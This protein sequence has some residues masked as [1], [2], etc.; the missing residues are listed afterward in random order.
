MVALVVPANQQPNEEI[1]SK[2]LEIL[3]AAK[4]KLRFDGSLT[5][6]WVDVTGSPWDRNRDG[7]LEIQTAW[8]R[9]HKMHHEARIRKSITIQSLI[10]FPE[11][12]M[13]TTL[14]LSRERANQFIAQL[15]YFDPHLWSEKSMAEKLQIIHTAKVDDGEIKTPEFQKLFEQIKAAGVHVYLQGYND[16]KRPTTPENIAKAERKAK[17]EAK[18]A[19]PDKVIATIDAGGGIAVDLVESDNAPQSDSD[20]QPSESTNKVPTRSAAKS[21]LPLDLKADREAKNAKAAKAREKASGGKSGT[22]KSAGTAT[23][24]KADPKQQGKTSKQKTP[25][26]S[27]K[28]P[29][30]IKTPKGPCRKPDGVV[31]NIVAE[32]CKGT[33]A[34]PKTVDQ[35]FNVLI[36]KFPDRGEKMRGTIRAFKS[37]GRTEKGLDVRVTADGK[38]IWV[39]QKKH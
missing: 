6:H 20:A 3:L 35:V 28:G 5:Q 26:R 14:V 31:A 38:G 17:R 23:V 11:D 33:E 24:T 37:W 8:N 12:P 10:P 27:V 15:G 25:T 21:Q 34:K 16:A 39:H 4:G 13:T 2:L 36:K 29:P 1:V 22:N 32:F 9:F 18:A 19:G 7:L 30:A